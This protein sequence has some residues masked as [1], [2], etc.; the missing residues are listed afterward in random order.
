MSDIRLIFNYV[1]DLMGRISGLYMNN[2]IL[3]SVIVLFVF[4]KL[5]NILRKVL[6]HG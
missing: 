1:L 3:S 4:G 2:F 5:V 6:P